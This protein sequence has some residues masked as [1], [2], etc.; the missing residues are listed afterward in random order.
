MDDLQINQLTDFEVE[1]L[2]GDILE[3]GEFL[4]AAKCGNTTYMNTFCY[5]NSS[6]DRCCCRGEC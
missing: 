2:Y 4:L 6:I 3:S 1:H 5:Y